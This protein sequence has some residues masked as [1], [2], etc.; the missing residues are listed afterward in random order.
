[1]KKYILLLLILTSCDIQKQ[2]TKQKN[3]IDYSEWVKTET[4]RKGDTVTFEIPKITYKDTVIK[5]TSTDGKTISKNYFDGQGKWVKSDC[6]SADIAESEERIIKYINQSLKKT[7]QKSEGIGLQLIPYIFAF[8]CFAFL[9]SVI[10]AF[11]YF[12]KS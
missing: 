1:M 7:S 8:I 4:F 11:L 5:V 12:K 3:D 9:T 10:A 2:A 6:I